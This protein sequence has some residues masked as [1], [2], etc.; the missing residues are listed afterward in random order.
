M[1][2]LI[3]LFLVLIPFP[4]SAEESAGS[5]APVAVS[6][7]T[8]PAPAPPGPSY[9]RV[10]IV[11]FENINYG[12]ALDQKFLG[13]LA[14]EGVNLANYYAIRHPSQPNY[15][16][17]VAGDTFGVDS[18]SNVD[19]DVRH[20]G[21]LL[22][23]KGKTWKVYA[24]SYPGRCF[25]GRKDSTYVRKHVPFL[26]FKNIQ[27]DKARCARIVDASELKKDI[28]KGTLP[29]FS[30]YIPDLNNDAHDT[31]IKYGDRWLAGAF[32]PRLKDP[33]F[34]KDMLFVVTFDEDAGLDNRILTV[35]Y[36]DS[37]K[38]GYVSKERYTHYSLLRT[39]EDHFGLG[40]LG[41]N[42]AGAKPITD[43]WR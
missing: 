2:P 26:S 43:V 3:L 9:K 13:K 5:S 22:E 4:S 17:L 21:D 34:M 31:G 7:T 19:L 15:I 33:A 36:G 8:A 25:L 30:L 11:I 24:E 35:L 32:G 41:K 38:P 16:A 12:P 6:T 40:T 23:A 18:D 39:L 37:V 14:K 42:D 1:I 27:T 10:M 29:D 28:R 20:L